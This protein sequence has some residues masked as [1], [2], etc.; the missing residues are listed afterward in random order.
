MG[1]KLS[2]IDRFQ[3]L[4]SIIKSRKGELLSKKFI[5]WTDK[6]KVECA[7]HHI[8]E[9]T[10]LLL[11][12]KKTWCS[13]CSAKQRSNIKKLTIEEMQKI[14]K[15]RGGSCNSSEYFNSKTKLQWE[16]QEGQLDKMLKNISSSFFQRRDCKRLPFQIKNP[17]RIPE[18]SDAIQL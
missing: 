9:T 2:K 18:E 14:A 17:I 3:E 4:K 16:C 10:P 8:W 13:T 7:S 12:Y 11:K 15:S 5:D 1:K 6:V